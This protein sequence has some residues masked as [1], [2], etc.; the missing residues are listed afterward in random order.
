MASKLDRTDVL[1]SFS[2]HQHYS[3]GVVRE[4]KLVKLRVTIDNTQKHKYC[5]PVWAI[6][7]A[8]A[9]VQIFLV[10]KAFSQ[11]AARFPDGPPY[12]EPSE[13]VGRLAGNRLLGVIPRL[14]PSKFFQP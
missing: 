10:P 3:D 4:A 13:Q 9:R 11:V 5:A 6:A 2:K 7:G 8:Q 12:L 1:V 14:P